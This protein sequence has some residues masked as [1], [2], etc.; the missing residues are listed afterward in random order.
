MHY[1]KYFACLI[2]IV[3]SNHEIFLTMKILDLWYNMLLYVVVNLLLFF[4]CVVMSCPLYSP[5]PR[6]KR[7]PRPPTWT[8]SFMPFHLCAAHAGLA[9][10]MLICHLEA[11]SHQLLQA[12]ISLTQSEGGY[13]QPHLF[14]TGEHENFR[15]SHVHHIKRGTAVLLNWKRR[16]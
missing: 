8:C 13:T 11:G 14:P 3:L 15:R 9:W 7:F 10:V 2:F 1:K 12:L 4:R 5:C 16:G 6:T